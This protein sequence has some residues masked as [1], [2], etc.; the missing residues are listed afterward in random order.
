MKKEILPVAVSTDCALQI[1]VKNEINLICIHKYLYQDRL[2]EINTY[3]VQNGY[4]FEL[5]T[6]ND[7]LLYSKGINLR[8]YQIVGNM[9]IL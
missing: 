8:E 4:T 7:G 2:D 3:M 1:G 5:F 9:S 6:P